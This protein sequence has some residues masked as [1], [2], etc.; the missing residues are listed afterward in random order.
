MTYVREGLG[1]EQEHEQEHGPSS[2]PKNYGNKLLREGAFED[3][4]EEAGWGIDAVGNYKL[5]P[6]RRG[7]G[8]N[9]FPGDGL[10]ESIGVEERKWRGVGGDGEFEAIG[11]ELLAPWDWIAHEDDH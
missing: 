3:E 2:F 11:I 10:N 1:K 7:Q 4:A 6:D 5:V 9:T 8:I